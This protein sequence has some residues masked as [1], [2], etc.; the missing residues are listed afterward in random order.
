M[1]DRALASDVRKPWSPTNEKPANRLIRDRNGTEIRVEHPHVSGARRRSRSSRSGPACR[2]PTTRRD[3]GCRAAT[4]PPGLAPWT[5]VRLAALGRARAP[6]R[7]R[8]RRRSTFRQVTRP[9]ARTPADPSRS[10]DTLGRADAHLGQHRLGVVVVT[11]AIHSP[12]GDQVGASRHGTTC[13]RRCDQA[14]RRAA[15]DR[16][17]PDVP[18]CPPRR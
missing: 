9:A 13:P 2:S 11:Y 1:S 5:A 15:G 16:R 3:D 18:T 8:S 6:A 7:R 4:S 17:Q 10:V 14:Y 12:S